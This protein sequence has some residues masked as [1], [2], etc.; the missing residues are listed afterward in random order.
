MKLIWMRW[1]IHASLC[2]GVSNLNTDRA[3]QEDYVGPLLATPHD[4]HVMPW[5]ETLPAYLCLS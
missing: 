4:V 3:L 5:L 2:Q 1:L